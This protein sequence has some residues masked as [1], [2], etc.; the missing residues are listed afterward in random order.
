MLLV[1]SIDQYEMPSCV[2]WPAILSQRLSSW[3]NLL[4]MKTSYDMTYLI[5]LMIFIIVCP[6]HG[7]NILTMLSL[8]M[9]WKSWNWLY[10]CFQVLKETATWINT[11][12]EQSPGSKPQSMGL[13]GDFHFPRWLVRKL[14]A[15]Q[16]QLLSALVVD[17]MDLPSFTYDEDFKQIVS[18]KMLDC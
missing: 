14:Q 3:L 15:V 16:D 17:Y 13:Y 4:K 7:I 2:L 10:S 12:N 9:I 11:C 6:F 1:V 18:C 5:Y 8:D